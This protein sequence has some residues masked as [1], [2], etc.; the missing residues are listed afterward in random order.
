[1]THGTTTN[2]QKTEAGKNV[3]DIILSKVFLSS[4]E[5]CLRAS[6]PLLIVLRAVDADERA[7]M[8]EVSALM[9]VAKEKIK[10]NFNTQNKAT[11]LKKTLG[12][13]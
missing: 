11:L 7:T 1:V 9:N 3:C 12:H 8:P 10:L 4:V 5:D 13:Y 2:R 6:T